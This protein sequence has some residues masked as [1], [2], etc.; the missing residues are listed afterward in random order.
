MPSNKILTDSSFL[1][2]LYDLGDSRHGVVAAVAKLYKGQF[3]TPQVVL[4]EVVYL[5]KREIG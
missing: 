3:L 4:T 2:A 5:L 1:I